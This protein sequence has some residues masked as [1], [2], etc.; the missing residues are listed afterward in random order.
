MRL[1]LLVFLE[2]VGIIKICKQK[3]FKMLYL[4]KTLEGIKKEIFAG[5]ILMPKGENDKTW[6]EACKRCINII[7]RYKEEKGIF[8]IEKNRYNRK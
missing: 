7:D 2:M 8:Q 3:G 4:E 6:N 5:M 1:K